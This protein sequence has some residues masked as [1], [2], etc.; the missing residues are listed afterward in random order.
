MEK[1]KILSAD[2][3][4]ETLERLSQE[5]HELWERQE[6]AKREKLEQVPAASDSVN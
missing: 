1:G 5:A 2:H 3:F 4:W 6:R